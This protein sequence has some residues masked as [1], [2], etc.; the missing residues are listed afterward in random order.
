[1][2][3]VLNLKLLEGAGF[4]HVTSIVFF[5]TENPCSWMSFTGHLHSH[6]NFPPFPCSLPTL[7]EHHNSVWGSPSFSCS[8]PLQSFLAGEE[9]LLA[10]MARHCDFSQWPLWALSF[11]CQV[12]LRAAQLLMANSSFRSWTQSPAILSIGIA[13][14]G[15]TSGICSCSKQE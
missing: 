12:S 14:V 8:L 3:S 7:T 4:F 13:E 6:A 5:V 11:S 9:V 2:L 10:G 1:M 15:N